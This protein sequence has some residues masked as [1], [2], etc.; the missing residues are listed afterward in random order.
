MSA[1][2]DALIAGM[3]AKTGVLLDELTSSLPSYVESKQPKQKFSGW[4]G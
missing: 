2:I 4:T 3:G 1:K